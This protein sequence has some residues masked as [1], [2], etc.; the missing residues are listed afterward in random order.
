MRR[1]VCFLGLFLLCSAVGTAGWFSKD[2][3]GFYTSLTNGSFYLD[4]RKD[5]S[6]KIAVDYDYRRVIRGS[7]QYT[8]PVLE[9]YFSWDEKDNKIVL[10]QKTWDPSK[11]IKSRSITIEGEDLILDGDRFRKLGSK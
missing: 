3:S 9:E 7:N 2:W 5:G 10:L 11:G 6:A 4:I 8:W 1:V